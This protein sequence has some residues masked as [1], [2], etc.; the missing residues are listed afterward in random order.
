M[1]NFLT[2]IGLTKKISANTKLILNNA[3]EMQGYLTN[4]S[5]N[6]VIIFDVGAFDGSISLK[7]ADLFPSSLIYS[8]EPFP[9]SFSKLV[10]KTSEYSNILPVNKGV[11]DFVGF[12]K[13]NS[14][15]FS[16]TNSLLNSHKL[17][18]KVWGKNL[19]DKK[20]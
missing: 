10:E 7:Y 11:G 2:L 3:F 1:K 15:K 20:K 5:N 13:F 17:A 4:Y 19:L 18:Y 8:F 12:A 6:N 16:Q 9:E 14:N